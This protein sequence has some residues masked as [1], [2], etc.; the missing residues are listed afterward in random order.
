MRGLIAVVEDGVS[1]PAIGAEDLRGA[2]VE[3]AGAGLLANEG[4][5][6]EDVP[7]D[8]G[9]GREFVLETAEQGIKAGLTIDLEAMI[10]ERE[11]DV[12]SGCTRVAHSKPPG[13]GWAAYSI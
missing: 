4:A 10:V 6:L 5:G 11:V 12:H 1:R 2:G 8:G 7:V 13:R 9:I 3:E